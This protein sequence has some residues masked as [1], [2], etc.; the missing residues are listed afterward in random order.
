MESIERI[1]A[2]RRRA[3]SSPTADLPLAVGPVRNQA[4]AVLGRS[5]DTSDFGYFKVSG[6]LSHAFCRHK[7][8]GNPSA[9]QVL[10]ELQ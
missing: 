4:S 9:W 7:S 8:V 3:S 10:E 1:S 2:S 6:E 5:V